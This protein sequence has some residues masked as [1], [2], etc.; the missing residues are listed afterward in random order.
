MDNELL[1]ENCAV[2]DSEN[3]SD[4]FFEKEHQIRSNVVLELIKDKINPEEKD[5]NLLSL[6]CSTG[7]IEEKIKKSLNI[8]VFGIDAAHQALKKA[9]KR[10]LLTQLGDIS[11]KLSFK[12]NFFDFVFAGEVIEHIF[13]TKAFLNEIHRVLK[14][15]GYLI[16]TTPNLARI[17]D[18]FKL[19]FGKTPRQT[20]PIH[21][22]LHLHIRPFTFDSLKKSL[23]ICNFSDITLRTN[24]FTIDFFNQEVRIY[25]KFL[26]KIFPTFGSTLIVRAHKS[27]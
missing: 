8:S 21:T 17:D 14:P 2:F 15:G 24:S 1:K 16:I 10:N 6:A 25:S 26:S 18:R 11:K 12:D 23:M 19:L 4:Y 20:S 3:D 13:D 5:I 27:I 7:V 22:H 9:A